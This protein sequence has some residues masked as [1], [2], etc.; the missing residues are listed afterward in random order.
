MNRSARWQEVLRPI[1]AG[2]MILS[3]PVPIVAYC[4][5]LH[6]TV[7]YVG[8][9]VATKTSTA[10]SC[11]VLFRPKFRSAVTPVCEAHVRRCMKYL[12]GYV[13]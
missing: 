7:G 10:Q 2:L 1:I 13:A 4:A 9:V 12:L 5:S 3:K 8:Y 6:G 11:N